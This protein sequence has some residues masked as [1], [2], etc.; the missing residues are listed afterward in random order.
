MI[1]IVILLVIFIFILISQSKKK[2]TKYSEYIPPAKEDHRYIEVSR[3]NA[4]RTKK[5]F[6]YMLSNEGSFGG[7]IIKIGMTRRDEPNARVKELSDAS[8]P[9]SFDVHM[10]IEVDNA[11]DFEK[12]LHSLFNDY[13][14][15][16]TNSRKEFFKIKHNDAID[17]IITNIDDLNESNF[18]RN[19]K[20]SS[21]VKSQSYWN[22][23][24]TE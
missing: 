14:Y 2:D 22:N 17:I 5:G 8:V 1:F 24:S 23:A 10:M 16:R 18:N 19:N 4:E 9:F 6:V 11:P 21:W 15:N 13:R 3:S 7:D 12:K 20:S